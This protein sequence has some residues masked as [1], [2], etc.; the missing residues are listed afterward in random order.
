MKK[1]GYRSSCS[2]MCIIQLMFPVSWTSTLSFI[3]QYRRT[4]Q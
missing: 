1:A 2:S 3:T 4:V